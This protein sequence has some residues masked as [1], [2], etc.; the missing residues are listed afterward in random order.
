MI[1]DTGMWEP[2]AQSSWKV[3][4][5]GTLQ[6]YS[7]SR[8]HYAINEEGFYAEKEGEEGEEKQFKVS[9]RARYSHYGFFCRFG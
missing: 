7:K 8:R 5:K 4:D 2:V 3:S 6:L 9:N 1:T